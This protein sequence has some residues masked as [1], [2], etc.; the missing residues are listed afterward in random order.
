M[1]TQQEFITL[2][3]ICKSYGSKKVLKD[4]SF[5]IYKGEVFSLLGV[6]GAGKTTLSSIISTL[7][8]KDSGD[9]LFENKS[10]YTQLATYR[11]QISFCTQHL[12]INP[13][14]TIEENLVFAARFYGISKEE[15]Q[16]RAKELMDQFELTSYAQ[17]NMH[18]LSGGYKQRLQ[19]ARSMMHYPNLI[20]LD[21]P[22]VGM[23]PRVRETLWKLVLEL[24]KQGVSILLTTHYLDEAEYLSDRVCLI[25]NGLIKAIDSPE[26]LKEKLNKKNLNE[27]FLHLIEEKKEES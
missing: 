25:D 15:S 6:N 26:A 11:H 5:T 4:I 20:I 24:K 1:H 7:I 18:V 23:D 10:I 9:I 2:K 22:T 27:I 21:E 8:K 19:L 13:A 3:N 16:K 14:L 12:S 17:A